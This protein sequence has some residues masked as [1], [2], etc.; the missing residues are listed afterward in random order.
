MANS[1]YH[2][3]FF[4]TLKV[5][6]LLWIK[7]LFIVSFLLHLNTILEKANIFLFFYKPGCEKREL[8]MVIFEEFS[9]AQF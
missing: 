4:F 1:V 7:S 6:P 5:L 9:E 2:R 3:I 8:Q